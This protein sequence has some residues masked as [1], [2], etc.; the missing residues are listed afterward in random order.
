MNV[1]CVFQYLQLI[2]QFK[3]C[4]KELEELK[5]SGFSTGDIKKVNYP[6]DNFNT[7]WHIK[8]IKYSIPCQ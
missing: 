6:L 7:N 8:H 2:E 4:H 1:A 5:T 3:E